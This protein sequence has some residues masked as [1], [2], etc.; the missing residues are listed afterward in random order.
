M[1]IN[2]FFRIFFG[3]FEGCNKVKVQGKSEVSV[4]IFEGYGEGGVRGKSGVNFEIFA[5]LMIR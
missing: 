3:D 4:E 5:N 2:L 1:K